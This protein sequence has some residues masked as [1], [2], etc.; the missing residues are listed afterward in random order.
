[1]P[2]VTPGVYPKSSALTMSFK[3]CPHAPAV[4]L[5]AG[6]RVALV[7]TR[8]IAD[9]ADGALAQLRVRRAQ[10]DHEI[11]ARASRT[12]HRGRRE[13]VEDE[14]RRGPCLQAARSREYFR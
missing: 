13:H 5:E 2:L 6:A 4:R 11:A 7:D 12:D 1:M 8:D 9:D 3:G 10:V 14:L